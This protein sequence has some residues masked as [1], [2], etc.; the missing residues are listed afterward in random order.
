MDN[1]PEETESFIFMARSL[2]F[3]DLQ[4]TKAQNSVMGRQPK[5][6]AYIA[7]LAVPSRDRF[8]LKGICASVHT[9]LF[10]Q[11]NLVIGIIQH[12][13]V[14]ELSQREGLGYRK[15]VWDNLLTFSKGQ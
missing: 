8:N 15:E 14:T 2:I 9:N 5:M 6:R 13:S 7:A 3:H 10:S 11:R 1:S 12:N 4:Q